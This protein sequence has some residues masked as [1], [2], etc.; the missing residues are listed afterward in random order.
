MDIIGLIVGAAFNPCNI[1][2]GLRFLVIVGRMN[3]FTP[4]DLSLL[5]IFARKPKKSPFKVPKAS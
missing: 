4:I 1:A 5:K 3:A 2:E